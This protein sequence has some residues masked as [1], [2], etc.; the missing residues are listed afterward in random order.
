[1]LLT[2]IRTCECKCAYTHTHTKFLS[3]LIELLCLA[4]V[5]EKPFFVNEAF[6]SEGEFY[7]WS[8]MV[9]PVI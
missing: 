2:K 4:V 6:A 1:M 8:K 5:L 7:S 9:F 3:G